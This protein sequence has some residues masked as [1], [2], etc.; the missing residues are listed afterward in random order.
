M[1]AK[2]KTYDLSEFYEPLPIILSGITPFG[3]SFPCH[4]L[5]FSAGKLFRANWALKGAQ[6]P[7]LSSAVS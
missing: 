5:R 1:L 3:A 6:F 4:E 7:D 2:I